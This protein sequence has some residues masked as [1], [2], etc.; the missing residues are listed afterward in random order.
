VSGRVLDRDTY[1]PGP[2]LT[3]RA[4]QVV[5]AAGAMFNPMIL[6]RSGL[7]RTEIGSHLSLHPSF[8]VMA[9]FDEP[10]RGW[11]GALQSAYGDQYE[12]SDGMLFNSVFVP[13]GVLAATLPGFGPAHAKLRAQVAHLGIFGGM[14]HD[15]AMGRVRSGFGREPVMTYRM[16]PRDRRRIPVLLRRMGEIWFA[17][18]AKEIFLPVFGAPGQTPDSFR[19]FDL[20]SVPGRKIECSSQHPLGTCA[21]GKD[22]KTSVVNDRGQVWGTQGLFVACGSIMPSSLGVNPQLAIMTM[23]LRLSTLLAETKNL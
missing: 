1:S 19:N 3:V 15:D 11:E 4:K 23:A 22:E 7:K 5:L 8:R 18:G 9:R 2:K 17:A 20:E 10:V 6:K 12:K 13:N 16:S 14:L 21:M